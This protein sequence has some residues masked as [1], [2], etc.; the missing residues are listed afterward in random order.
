VVATESDW[1]LHSADYRIAAL[2]LLGN[3]PKIL[4]IWGSTWDLGN[5]PSNLGNSGLLWYIQ[6]IS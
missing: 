6:E 5:F 1:F 4:G 2:P 3:F